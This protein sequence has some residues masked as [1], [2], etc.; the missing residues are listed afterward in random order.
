MGGPGSCLLSAIVGEGVRSAHCMEMWGPGSCL[1]SAIVGEGV[2]SACC[3]DNG[4]A[5]QWAWYSVRAAPSRASV[6]PSIDRYY[7]EGK[8]HLT[9]ILW[10][11]ALQG[12]VGIKDLVCKNSI[13][14]NALV[15][16]MLRLT[17]L[18]N[19]NVFEVPCYVTRSCRNPSAVY[20]CSS[21]WMW[22]NWF[23]QRL[24]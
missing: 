10:P 5:R 19:K 15:P 17:I 6:R 7:R 8:L 22:G 12:N 2:R 4:R 21:V 14:T 9:V 11:L 1:L 13:I 24:F 18:A 3:M 23:L 20:S 16:C